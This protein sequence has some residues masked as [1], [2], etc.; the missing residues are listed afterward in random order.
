MHFS[1]RP[2][3]GKKCRCEARGRRNVTTRRL[4]SRF[5]TRTSLALGGLEANV[6]KS[7]RDSVRCVADLTDGERHSMLASR[8]VSANSDGTRHSRNHYSRHDICP[9]NCS[10]AMAAIGDQ[11]SRPSLLV[12]LARRKMPSKCCLTTANSIE[13]T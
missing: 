12:V 6:A 4:D 13:C 1:E 8:E 7:R 11:P 2:S 10:T 9:V 3:V 5:V